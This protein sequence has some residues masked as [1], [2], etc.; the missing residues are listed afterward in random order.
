MF[1][2]RSTSVMLQLYKSLVRCRVEYSCPLWNPLKVDNSQKVED[3]QRNFTRRFAGLQNLNYWQRLSKLKLLSL[4]RRRERYM[5]IHV[6][7]ISSQMLQMTLIWSSDK[8]V[9]S[10]YGLRYHPSQGLLLKQQLDCMMNPLQSMLIA[11]KLWNI[12]PKEITVVKQLE[13][14][15]ILL[16]KFLHKY[17]DQP[18]TKGYTASNRNSLIDWNLMSGGPQLA[19]WPC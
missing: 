15:K 19:L 10:G 9:D 3:I 5:I 2:N 1:K 6:W 16:N 18:Q 13:Q 7:K 14:L 11:G 4:Q 12:L 17:P 8:T